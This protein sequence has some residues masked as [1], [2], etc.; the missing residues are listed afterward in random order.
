MFIF[1]MVHCIVPRSSYEVDSHLRDCGRPG[2]GL[3]HDVAHSWTRS[4]L[5]LTATKHTHGMY[6]LDGSCHTSISG[7][8]RFTHFTFFSL[9]P[10][11]IMN[12]II[13]LLWD[14]FFPPQDPYTDP[15][16]THTCRGWLITRS[17]LSYIHGPGGFRVIKVELTLFYQLNLIK[18]GS[19]THQE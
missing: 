7:K 16:P 15:Y 19:Y 8:Y 3:W 4:R 10:M 11:G 14:F 17:P 2:V 18:I 6:N 12:A 13:S 1:G 5:S 9:S